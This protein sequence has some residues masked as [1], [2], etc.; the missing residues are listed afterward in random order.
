MV[1]SIS[2]PAEVAC[3]ECTWKFISVLREPR[4]G[5]SLIRIQ[6][7]QRPRFAHFSRFGERRGLLNANDDLLRITLFYEECLAVID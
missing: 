6:V 1:L 2:G 7:I 4:D 3:A 5:R